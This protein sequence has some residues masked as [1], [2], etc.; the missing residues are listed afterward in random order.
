MVTPRR[1]DRSNLAAHPAR[2]QRH[3]AA[4]LS[5]ALF[6]VILL[7][8]A[9]SSEADPSATDPE[10]MNRPAAARVV[11]VGT[12]TTSIPTSEAGDAPAP[13]EGDPAPEDGSIGNSPDDAADR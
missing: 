11:L 13:D 12:T 5:V 3:L 8:A 7:G 4:V 2:V 6:F 10:Q 1:F 9:A